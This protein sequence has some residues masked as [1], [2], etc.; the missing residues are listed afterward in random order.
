MSLTRRKKFKIPRNFKFPYYIK[1]CTYIDR[2][3]KSHKKD[4]NTLSAD[5]MNLPNPE[6]FA[7]AKEE[8]TGMA[9][10]IRRN[11]QKRSYYNLLD[12]P[13]IKAYAFTQAVL[14][15][16]GHTQKPRLFPKAI[17]AINT[18]KIKQHKSVS[19]LTSIC[20]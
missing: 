10:I 7:R 9:M 11:Y 1:H 5:L 17:D 3:G 13:L 4:L 8:V 14:T 2:C 19:C 6:A 20:G 18:L 16:H 15:R 12:A